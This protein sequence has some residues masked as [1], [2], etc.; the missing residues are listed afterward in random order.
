MVDN[1]KTV[2]QE[3]FQEQIKPYEAKLLKTRIL[4]SESLNQAQMAREPVFSF[5]P[6]GRGAQ[7]YEELT[8]ELLQIYT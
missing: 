7:N 3:F 1:R 4:M 8:Q 2:S 6:K 5:D